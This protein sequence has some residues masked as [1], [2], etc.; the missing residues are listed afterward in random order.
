MRIPDNPEAKSRTKFTYSKEL[1]A[2]D[3]SISLTAEVSAYVTAIVAA[4]TTPNAPAP[5]T[6]EGVI[7]SAP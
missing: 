5:G 7:Q 2:L 6:T 1:D 3:Y 4:A